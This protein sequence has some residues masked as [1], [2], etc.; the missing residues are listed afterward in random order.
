MTFDPNYESICG[1]TWEELLTQQ[2]P[3]LMSDS[4]LFTDWMMRRLRKVVK[5]NY[6][7]FSREAMRRS[8]SIS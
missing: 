6:F 3:T 7:S 2:S 8:P 5:Y 4:F 1:T